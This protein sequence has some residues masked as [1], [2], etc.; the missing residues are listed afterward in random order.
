MGE[1]TPRQ[2]VEKLMNAFVQ[3]R[4]DRLLL[5]IGVVLEERSVAAVCREMGRSRQWGAGVVA[6][7]RAWVRASGTADMTTRSHKG[8]GK[9]RRSA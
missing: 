8:A 6:A 2:R 9:L 1:E 3:G 5:L 4:A 7:W